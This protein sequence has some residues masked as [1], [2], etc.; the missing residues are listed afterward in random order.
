V[1]CDRRSD[2]ISRNVLVDVGPRFGHFTF[3]DE[4]SDTLSQFG[5]LA[6]THGKRHLG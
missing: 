2:F 1:M 5:H 4:F 3:D 6:E